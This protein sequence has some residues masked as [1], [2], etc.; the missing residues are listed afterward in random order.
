MTLAASNGVSSALS[1]VHIMGNVVY[2]QKTTEG[3]D[4]CVYR[5]LEIPETAKSHA[6]SN[7]T[8]S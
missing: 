1:R 8:L 3:N 6:Y 4:A 2:D 5:L 7:E